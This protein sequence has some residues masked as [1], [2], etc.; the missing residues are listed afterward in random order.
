M[1]LQTNTVKGWSVVCLIIKEEVPGPK[2]EI[3]NCRSFWATKLISVVHLELIY[4]YYTYPL[5]G[6]Y[7]A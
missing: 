6:S 2:H 4:L 7:H 5:D 1:I 3:P